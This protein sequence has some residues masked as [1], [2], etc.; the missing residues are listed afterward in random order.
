MLL[1]C[2]SA[3]GVVPCSVFA[4]KEL[5]YDP[6][7][8]IIFVDKDEISKAA[9][10][11]SPEKPAH[12]PIRQK[13]VTPQSNSDL[14]V[15]RKKD[16][17]D[18]YFKSG[19]E[20]Y[21]NSDFNNALK[22]F[23]H[24]DSLEQSAT[25]RLYAG[26]ALRKLGREKEFIKEM[27]DILNNEPESDV[28]DDALLELAVYYKIDN[29]YERSSQLFTRLIEQYPFGTDIAT[30]EELGEL[31][32]EQRRLMR[33]ELINMLMTLGFSADDLSSALRK[34]Q[35][36]KAL[37][38]SGTGD[39]VTVESLK[40]LHRESVTKSD[41]QNTHMQKMEH[42]KPWLYGAGV[43]GII[44]VL[45]FLLLLVKIDAQKKNIIELRKIIAD[46]EVDKI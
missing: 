43:L 12:L 26:K 25:Y 38:E 22:N 11:K 27:F 30:G 7:K 8:G 18:L 10:G 29:D 13:K 36:D 42:V 46:L 9:D 20:Y 28:A 4:E 31:A 35:H 24:A 2:L 17:P 37:P 16:P 21:K 1:V 23:M 5:R 44:N 19:L 33:A 34:F 45:L 32:R 41:K 6:E 40:S 15:G 3:G 39:K 14:H